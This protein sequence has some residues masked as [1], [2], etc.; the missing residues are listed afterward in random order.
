MTIAIHSLISSVCREIL[1]EYKNRIKINMFVHKMQYSLTLEGTAHTIS[2][3]QLVK[4]RLQHRFFP[5]KY[6]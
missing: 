2:I 6:W 3:E 1:T 5:V 4:E